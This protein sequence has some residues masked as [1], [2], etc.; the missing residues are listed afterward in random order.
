MKKNMILLIIFIL[1]Q[2]IRIHALEYNCELSGEDKIYSKP[3]DPNM[4]YRS[5]TSL[6]IDISNI[7]NISSFTVYVDYDNEIVGLGNCNLLNYIGSG[8]SITSDKKVFYN[9]KY[10]DG[11]LN[12]FDKY[13]LY[14]ISFMPKDSTPESGTTEVKVYFE[15]AK[16]KN[17]NPITISS[18][19][20]S[21][22]FSKSG[23]YFK[24]DTDETNN[25]DGNTD[26]IKEKETNVKNNSN[27]N[28]NDSSNTDVMK[29]LTEQKSDNNYA[30]SIEIDGY[31]LDFNK[32]KTEYKIYI[33]DDVNKITIDVNVENEKATYKIVGNDDLKSNDYKVLVEVIAENGQKKTYTIYTEISNEEDNNKNISEENISQVSTSDEKEIKNDNEDS[34]FM[35]IIIGVSILVVIVLIISSIISHKKTKKMEKM[36][37]EF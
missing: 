15:N 11:Y 34:N 8:C 4:M 12:L 23:M 7:D 10:S 18:C 27:T 37:D 6:Y 3:S 33:K 26:N 1:M 24:N 22:S 32:E 16:D 36:F 31:D 29:E 25:G 9:Y 21:Y 20:K 2:P 28:V 5:S 13:K 30:K 19:N 17:G 14:T 35:Y